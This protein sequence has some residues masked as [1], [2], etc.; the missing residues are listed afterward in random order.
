MRENGLRIAKIKGSTSLKTF[1]HLPARLYKNDSRWVPSLYVDEYQFHDAQKNPAFKNATVERWIA[2]QDEEPVGRIMGIIHHTYNQVQQEKTARFFQMDCVN[3]LAVSRLLIT[4]VEQW[5]LEQGMNQLIGPFG[6]SDKDPQGFQIEGLEHLPVIATPA[7]PAYMPAMLDRLGYGKYLDCVSYRIPIPAVLPAL[8][9]RVLQR[10]QQNKQVHLLEFTSRRALK[11]YVV[12][13]FQLINE[14]YM[15]LFGFIPM[16]EE[17]IEKM[18]RQYLPI[19]NPAFVKAMVDDEGQL[20]SFVVAMPDMSKGLQ[21]AK[22][23]L[24]PFGILHIFSAMRK[25][26]QLNLLLGAV[27]DGYRGK[28]LDV[29]MAMALIK[30]ASAKGMTHMDSH[31]ILETNRTMRAE[32]EKLNGELYKRFRV[33]VKQ[34][35]K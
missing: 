7:H 14:T 3:D 6:F 4:T 26:R 8:Y 23:K 5:A 19:L 35:K 20:L 29:Y 21:K 15:P 31:L 28:G 32:C 27:K 18:A 13:V 33:F 34:L 2:Y 17:E 16:S 10:V 25:T 22:G 9:K 11:P 12:P 1:I 30:T 24:F